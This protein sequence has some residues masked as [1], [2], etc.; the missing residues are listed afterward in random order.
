M[1]YGELGHLLVAEYGVSVLIDSPL[2]VGI[3]DGDNVGR[4]IGLVEGDDVGL[5]VGESYGIGLFV[6]CVELGHQKMISHF[7]HSPLDS[8]LA[9]ALG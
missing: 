3:R 6:S 1:S 4:L 8:V 7:L 2:T 9:I 5:R